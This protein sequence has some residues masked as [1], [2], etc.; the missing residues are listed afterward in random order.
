MRKVIAV[1]V[2]MLGIVATG[3]EYEVPLAEKQGL[4][5]DNSVLGIWE[6]IGPDGKPQSKDWMR[7]S[8]YSET[9]YLVRFDGDKESVDYRGYP[10][11]FAGVPCLQIQAISK[12]GGGGY[13]VFSYELLDGDLLIKALNPSLVSNEL[14]SSSELRAAFLRHKSNKDL[15]INESRFRKMSQEQI[16]AR[17]SALEKERAGLIKE[18]VDLYKRSLELD[19]L[20]ASIE[21]DIAAVRNLL[22]RGVNPNMKEEEGN[23]ALMWAI[24]EAHLPIVQALLAKGAD[25]NAKAIDGDTA[26]IAAAKKGHLPVVEALLAN[27]AD[28]E[29]MDNDGITALKW[30]A[31]E[32]QTA[33][34]QELLTKG[35]DV[36]AKDNYGF[37]ALNTAA[38]QGH[39]PVVQ[40][41]LA[42]G[43]NPNMKNKDGATALMFAAQN[44]HA[45]VV[46]ALLA[47]GADVN[48]KTEKGSTALEFAS[49]KGHTAVVEV[50]RR[51]Q[52][53]PCPAN[54]SAQ[55]VF[56]LNG[57]VRTGVVIKRGD[58]ITFRASGRVSFGVIAGAG[59]PEGINGFRGYNLI[60]GAD[61]QHGA[62]IA[63]I[64]QQYAN[65]GWY[66]IGKG[67][68]ITSDVDGTL[69]LGVNDIDTSNNRGSFTVVVSICRAR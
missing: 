8:R 26:L 40:T 25:V 5:I 27:G 6:S 16:D 31:F 64:K 57:R 37:T 58:K 55:H 3:C 20:S 67:R 10:I 50:L 18:N 49:R 23:T 24:R 32:G 46:R 56:Q 45:A 66:Y 12:K 1:L 53:K 43:A 13:F 11:R 42:N 30:A 21:G 17:I 63:R 22:A 29:A 52:N 4:P 35:A 59:G 9:E 65:D 34:V 44:G 69:E 54:L 33:V 62:F 38:G 19:L 48:A 60:R 36:N 7:I 51:A 39:L 15:F 14:K 61:I 68:V 47:K 2:I 28:V 41:L